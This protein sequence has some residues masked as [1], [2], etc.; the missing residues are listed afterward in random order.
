MGD[1]EDLIQGKVLLAERFPIGDWVWRL[2][3]YEDELIRY[4]PISFNW[5]EMRVFETLECL[6]HLECTTAFLLVKR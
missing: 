6:D 2:H 4:N 3:L 5:N 1:V